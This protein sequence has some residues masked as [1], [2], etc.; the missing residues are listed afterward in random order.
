MAVYRDD[1]QQT[2][3]NIMVSGDDGVLKCVATATCFLRPGKT[4][5]F[6]V[7]VLDADAMAANLTQVEQVIQGYMAEEYAKAQASGVPVV[8]LDNN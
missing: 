7:D 6:N 3:C 2:S 8:A 4:L 5:A 1:S